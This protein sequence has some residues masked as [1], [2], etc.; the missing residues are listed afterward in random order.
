MQPQ[1][2]KTVL[3]SGAEYF[4]D[5]QAIN[6]FMDSAQVVD[7]A[8][9]IAEHTQLRETLESIGVTVVKTAAPPDLQDGVYTANWALVRGD[10]AVLSSLP[11]S[12]CGEQRYAEEA[13]KKLGKRVYTVP[14]DRKFS[15]QGDALPCGN[16]LF[17]GSGYRTDPEVHPYL[18]ETLGYEVMTLRTIPQID[19]TGNPV[20]NPVSGWADSYFYDLDLALSVLRFPAAEQKGLIAWCPEAFMPESRDTLANFG[21]VEKIEVS[22]A[23]AK[24]AFACN[25]VSTGST[26]VMSANAPELRAAIEAHGL[27]TITLSM[28]ELAKGGGFIRCTTLTLDNE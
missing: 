18:A 12:R 25:L 13:L 22:F 3:M 9:A 27:Q 17:C 10:K 4:D 6:P 7:V 16:Y 26:V 5:G 24:E 21:G 20:T 23:E 19:K 2:N 15:G 14:N 8:R 11:P 1:M 28:P